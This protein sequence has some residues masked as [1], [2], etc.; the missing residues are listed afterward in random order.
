MKLLLASGS[1]TRRRM[2]ADAGVPFEAA[3]SAVDEDALKSRLIGMPPQEIAQR[4]AD[5]KARSLATDR[6]TLVL[7]SDQVLEQADG[8]ILSKAE[9]QGAGLA[10]LRGL[11]G[12]THKLHSTASLVQDG[13][14]IWRASETAW[15]SM[16]HLSDAEIGAYLKTEWPHV[17]YNVGLYRIEG[18]GVQLF[19]S[20]EGSHFAILGMPL[21]PL[22]AELRRR[23]V[24]A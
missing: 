7:G 21:L 13:T 8:S 11:A 3:L 18:P 19:E 17:R 23:G 4:L 24:I 22:L 20:I 14:V 2:L 5:A 9:T 16:R 12:R 1:A 15:L 10:Q 6:R